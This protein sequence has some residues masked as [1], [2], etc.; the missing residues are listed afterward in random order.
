M[1]TPLAVWRARPKAGTGGFTERQ[2]LP[3]CCLYQL[4]SPWPG[5]DLPAC[6]ARLTHVSPRSR[7]QNTCFPL[8]LV[9][10][11]PSCCPTTTKTRPIKT[12]PYCSRRRDRDSVLDGFAGLAAHIGLGSGFTQKLSY[13]L[14]QSDSLGKVTAAPKG[15]TVLP[16]PEGK[17]AR[18]LGGPGSVPP[19]SLRPAARDVAPSRAIRLSAGRGSGFWFRV[20]NPGL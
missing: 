13:C 3:L 17:E 14:R 12:R 7:S 11:C 16:C 6:S 4:A 5:R 10:V 9:I 19:P 8:P 1:E 15:R 20:E 2:P 18:K